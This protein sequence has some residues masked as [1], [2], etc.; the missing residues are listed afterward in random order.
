MTSRNKLRALALGVAVGCTAPA[1]AATAF[2][3]DSPWMLGDWGGLRS[4]LL[5]KGVDFQLA[6][7]SETAGNVR[8]GYTG[9]HTA[10]YADQW[11]LGATFDL[12]KL[13]G[14]NA[15]QAQ[16]QFTDR[17]GRSLDDD[18]LND[19]RAGGFAATQQIHGR[20]SVTR[21]TE[22]W[23]SKGW[24]DD[25]LNVKGGRFTVSDEFAVQDCLFQN[26]AFCGSQ[27]G[28]YVNDIYN[29][30]TSSWA[31]RI[32]YRVVPELAAQV[33]V[34][35]IDPSGLENDNAMKL[36]T[37]GTRG[38]L[39]PAELVWTPQ[40]NHLPGEYRLG[41]YYNTANH[42]D[43]YDG[44]DGQPA[45]L[46]GENYRSQDSRHGWWITAKQQVTARGGD[47]NRGLVLYASATFHDRATNPVDSYQHTS[48]IYKGPFDARPHD[49]LG[50][51][52]ARIHASSRYLRNAKL[53]N[54]LSGLGDNAL[55]YI[56]EQHTAYIAELNYGIQATGWLNLMP[57]IQYVRNPGGVREVD[58]AVVLG[59]QASSTF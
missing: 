37:H 3:P 51:A 9:H 6:Y 7:L 49:T 45:A 40:P 15:T 35:N 4:E 10:R 48:M 33:G 44:A 11:T 23:L 59:L 21:I 54:D 30:P 5:A 42:D 43:V 2:A 17:N 29:S 25:R 39:L 58:N 52:V 36:R 20:G 32:R 12:N 46:T 38:M 27:P 53:Q 24:F 16:I 19:P 8:G 56:P 18:A 28:N 1:F 57:N 26:L 13:L 41:Y 31:L 55:G 22:L 50:L 34:Y 47:A 14:W